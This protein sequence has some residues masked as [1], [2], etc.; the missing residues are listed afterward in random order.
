[1]ASRASGVTIQVG[2]KTERYRHAFIATMPGGGHRG[3]YERKGTARLPIRELYGPSVHGMMARTDVLPRIAEYLNERLLVN[4]ARQID[5]RI[6]RDSG[7]V[8]RGA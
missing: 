5:R 1:R 7:K 8:P 3:V 6:R 4:L 2:G